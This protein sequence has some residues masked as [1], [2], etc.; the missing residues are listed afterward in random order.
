MPERSRALEIHG[1]SLEKSTRAL[2]PIPLGSLGCGDLSGGRTGPVSEH[3]LSLNLPY[4]SLPPHIP[5]RNVPLK[6]SHFHVCDLTSRSKLPLSLLCYST[7]TRA[8]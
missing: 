2:K 6:I 5:E 3:T 7:A 1:L 8:C 4:A